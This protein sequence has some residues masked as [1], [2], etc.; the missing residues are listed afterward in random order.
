[1][2]AMT[3]FAAAALFCISL[4]TNAANHNTPLQQ[5]CDYDAQGRVTTRTTFAW[6]GDDW[7]PALQWTYV[8]T[9]TGY[10]VELSRYDYRHKCFGEPFS[11]SE[12]AF[13][14][15]HSVAYVNNY[16]R[17]DSTHA[18]ELTSTM[19]GTPDIEY[20]DGIDKNQ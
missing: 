15:V 8:Y 19:P 18:Y 4:T 5:H 12:Y 7:Q 6:N 11:K 20:H 13:T 3:F 16:T 14:A 9:N 1:M 17:N 2:K 10:T